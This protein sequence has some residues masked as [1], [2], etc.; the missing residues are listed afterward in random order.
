MD[1][2]TI[3]TDEKTVNIRINKSLLPP[4]KLNDITSWLRYMFLKDDHIP[5]VDDN[6]EK[7]VE[8]RLDSLT[9]VDRKIIHEAIIQI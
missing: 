2:F 4:D 3:T 1:A 8:E 5:A 6:E 7:E 9:I